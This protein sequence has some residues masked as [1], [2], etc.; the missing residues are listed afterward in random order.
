MF[1]QQILKLHE[2]DNIAVVLRQI[3]SETWLR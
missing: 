2:S 3:G 1:N